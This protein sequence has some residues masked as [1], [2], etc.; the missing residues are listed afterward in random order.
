[1]GRP[2]AGLLGKIVAMSLQKARKGHHRLFD[3]ALPASPIGKSYG[4]ERYSLGLDLRQEGKR[5]LFKE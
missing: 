1:M 3:I 2:R 4:A 5:Y